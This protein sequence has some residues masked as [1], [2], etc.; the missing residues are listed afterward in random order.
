M[1][2]R[3]G[4]LIA[5]AALTAC[6]TS[7]DMPE[8]PE[9]GRAVIAPAT[10]K[11]L[12]NATPR[13]ERFQV[14][15]DGKDSTFRF[16]SAVDTRREAD[17][18]LAV[19]RHTVDVEADVSCWYCSGRAYHYVVKRN[20]CVL[21]QA[22]PSSAASKTPKAKADNLSWGTASDAK[23]VVVAD[24]GTPKTRWSFIGNPLGDKGIIESIEFPCRCLRSMDDKQNTS[25]GL[26]VC[27]R[28][29]PVQVW[30]ALKV[31]PFSDNRYRF[32]NTGRGI[33]EACLTEGPAPDKLLVQRGCNDTPEQLWLLTDNTSGTAGVS[34]W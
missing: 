28:N 13:I 30:Q 11:V 24:A 29:D 15:V 21:Q 14:R 20:V 3:T 27:D 18:N 23:V 5:I 32:Q 31:L 2:P 19:G 33:S 26:A 1:L 10:T 7:F 4:M 17:L 34:P 12:V 22:G 16:N 8:P 6:N 25:I 9:L